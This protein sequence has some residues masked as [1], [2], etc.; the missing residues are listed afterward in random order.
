MLERLVDAAA[1]Q[2]GLDPVEFRRQNLIQPDEFPYFIP[3]GNLYDSGNYAAVL[4]QALELLDYDGLAHEAGAARAAGPLRRHRPRHLPG[5]Q[6]VQRHRVL[7][8]V[9]RARLRR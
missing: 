4:D 6:R 9:R 1:D 2:L 8:L 3:T 5:A 7:V